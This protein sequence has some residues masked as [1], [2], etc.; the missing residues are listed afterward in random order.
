MTVSII[1]TTHYPQ[2]FLKYLQFFI[3][4]GLSSSHLLG[5]WGKKISGHTDPSKIFTVHFFVFA[6]LSSSHL[7]RSARTVSN[8][9][10]FSFCED[11]VHPTS[12]DELGPLENFWT[13][14]NFYNFHFARTEFIPP[15]GMSSDPSQIFTFFCFCWS[16]FIP[17]RG[18]SSDRLKFLQFFILRGPSSSHLLG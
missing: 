3:L 8:F 10:N 14:S 6:G 17:P 13:V 4:Q 9:Y 16:E 1:L 11:R 2:F 5:L 12:W 15:P 7:V 18:I